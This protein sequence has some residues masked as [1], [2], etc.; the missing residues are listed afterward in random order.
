[1]ARVLALSGSPSR[2]S[3]TAALLRSVEARLHGAGH[4]VRTVA[5]RELPAGPLLAADTADPAIRDVVDAVARADALVVATP[6]YKAAYSGLLKV[7]LDLLP[8]RALTGKT[9]LPLAT[10]G[11][12]AH[13]LAIDYAL[14]PVLTALGT[15]AVLRGYFV[16]DRLLAVGPDGAAALD[17][18]AARG[19][20][21][22][23]DRLA[24]ALGPATDVDTWLPTLD[25]RT[26][27]GSLAGS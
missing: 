25:S 5:V 9:V 1:M 20:A 4:T 23:V 13:V 6:V 2:S 10:G 12:T 21:D 16:L 7:L 22:A 8:Q 18:E 27:L 17:P 19:L 14:R 15:D 24:A 3:R 11:S 26:P